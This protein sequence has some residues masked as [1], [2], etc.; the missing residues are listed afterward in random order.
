MRLP[1]STYRHASIIRAIVPQGSGLSDININ[2]NYFRFRG[3]QRLPRI[4]QLQ[5]HISPPS[6]HSSSLPHNF[7]YLFPF[8]AR[9]WTNTLRLRGLKP[10]WHQKRTAGSLE[11]RISVLPHR[12]PPFSFDSSRG[13][14]CTASGIMAMTADLLRDNH[15]EI[16]HTSASPGR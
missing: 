11:P 5:P 2:K 6:L 3:C 13:L 16:W 10:P 4:P 15:V 9:K 1:Y 12:S 14:G 7:T 8:T